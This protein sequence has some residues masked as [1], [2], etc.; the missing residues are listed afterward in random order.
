MSTYES[1]QNFAKTLAQ[2]GSID[3]MAREFLMGHRYHAWAW[4]LP[5]ALD[6]IFNDEKNYGPLPGRPLST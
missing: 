6:F 4:A 1:N 5:A 3:Y 2:L